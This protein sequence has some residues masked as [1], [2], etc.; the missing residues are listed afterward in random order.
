MEIDRQA[1]LYN[2]YDSILRKASFVKYVI[3]SG[4]S[5]VKISYELV[6]NC[7][8]NISSKFPVLNAIHI[9]AAKMLLAYQDC[10]DGRRSVNAGDTTFRQLKDYS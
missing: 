6:K 4:K 7:N 9:T 10:T 8:T 1:S 2:I 5:N 3:L